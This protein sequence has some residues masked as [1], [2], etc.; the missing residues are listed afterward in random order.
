MNDKRKGPPPTERVPTQEV[1]P[2][3][4]FSAWL[5]QARSAQTS[6]ATADVPCGDC[7]GCCTSSY[8]IHIGPEEK[9]SLA[10]I[11]KALLFKAPGYPSGHVLM[12]YDAQGHCPMLKHGKCTIYAHRPQT[13]RDYDCRVFAAAGID[14]GDDDKQVINLRVKQWRFDLPSDRDAQ[15]LRAVRLA[16]D[17]LR[18]Y[19]N[20]FPMGFVPEHPTQLALLAITVFEAFLDVAGRGVEKVAFDEQINAAVRSMHAQFARLL[21]ASPRPR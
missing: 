10:R 7:T 8:F 5:R 14:A 16:T 19:A 6:K 3:G 1:L 9:E 11:P 21:P 4:A 20:T 18:E 2:A 15:E 17:Y 12:G 13:C